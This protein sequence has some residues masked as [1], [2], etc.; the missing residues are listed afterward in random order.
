MPGVLRTRGL[1]CKQKTHELVT[2]GPPKQSGT[3]CAIGFNGLL[4]A[5]PGEPGFLA[6]VTP[7]KLAS[8]ELGASVGA[9]EPHD[10]AVRRNV[11]RLVTLQRPSH[12]ASYVRDDREAPLLPGAGRA[13]Q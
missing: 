1:V 13:T 5:L 3:P 10:F 12:P 9:P 8:H 6:T 7:E 11:I 2:T 4:R